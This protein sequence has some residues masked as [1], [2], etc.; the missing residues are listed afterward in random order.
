MATSVPSWWADDFGVVNYYTLWL[1]NVAMENGPFIDGLPSY[2]MVI[3]HGYVSHNQMVIH[4]DCPSMLVNYNDLTDLPKPGISTSQDAR[5]PVHQAVL[6]SLSEG[7]Q[8]FLRPE[9]RVVS[10]VSTWKR[11]FQKKKHGD[12]LHCMGKFH[13]YDIIEILLR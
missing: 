11:G 6:A 3:F 7:M 13:G 5:F 2:K 4:P 8:R 10:T 1:F 9:I 12:T